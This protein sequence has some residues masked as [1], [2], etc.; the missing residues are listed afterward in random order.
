MHKDFDIRTTNYDIKGDNGIMS[1]KALFVEYGNPDAP[2]T[3][4]NY[5]HERDGKQYY[6]MYLV[7]MNCVDEYEA[8]MRIVGSQKHWRKLL[9]I[10]W[11]V[12]GIDLFSHEGLEQWREDMRARDESRA[13][14]LLHKA[15]EAG[16]VNAASKLLDKAK[17][18]GG[19]K[20]SGRPSKQPKL[21]DEPSDDDIFAGF[22]KAL[23]GSTH[24]N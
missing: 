5:H 9:G 3:F 2:Y 24:V 19:V 11:F 4:K 14:E 8:A 13:K 17:Q 10:K 16:N 20:G 22:N 1:T 18:A 6:S 21:T 15:A 23:Q 7:Y 12:E